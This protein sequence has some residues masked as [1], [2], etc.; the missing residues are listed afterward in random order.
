MPK[1]KSPASK[2]PAVATRGIHLDLKGTPPTMKRLIELLDV[3][4]AA[5]Y[6]ALL[7]EWEDMFPWTVS[8]RMRCE[9]A[10]TPAEVI[11]LRDAAAARN[12]EIIPLVQCLG[13]M[14]TPLSLP[15]FAP[16]REVSYRSDGLDP[17]HP[18]SRKL[19]EAMVDDVLALLPGVRRFH[20]GGDEART[21]GKGPRTTRF[22]KKYGKA[23]LYLQHIEPILARLNARGVRPILW[24]DMMHAWPAAEIRK[25]ARK[26]DLCP[27]GYDSHPDLWQHHSAT[28]YIKRFHDNG[29]TLWGATAYKGATDHNADLCDF[30][31]QEENSLAWVEVAKRFGIIGLFATAWSRH[32]THRTQTQPIDACLDSLVNVGFILHDGKP[33]GRDACLDLLRR[34]GELKRFTACRSAMEKLADARHNAWHE[35]QNLR[36]QI[37]LETSDPIRRE[38]A[39]GM[40]F[41][42]E[43]KRHVEVGAL[44]AAAEMR[45]SF[46]GLMPS[47]WIERYLSDRI[48]P[49]LEELAALDSRVR[50]LEPA[51]YKATIHQ[52]KMNE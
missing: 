24:S 46:R 42:L 49:L 47:I 19:V 25:I 48:E 33:S 3:I 27:W 14:E 51:A 30:A 18:K 40:W 44:G 29:V 32:S 8:R 28:R 15:E 4:A 22:A 34:I 31:Q 37:T 36:E 38:S 12:L 41:F 50:T 21:L 20:L 39:R 35:V 11:R 16:L 13:H 7:I 10:Y 17:L 52:R 23:A 45:K 2:R 5:K 43:L 1:S 9:T 26:A 6:N